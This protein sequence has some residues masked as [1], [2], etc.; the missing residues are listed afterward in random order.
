MKALKPFT[1]LLVLF[2]AALTVSSQNNAILNYLAADAKTI[3]KINPASLRQ[4]MKWEDLMKYKMFE[5]FLKGVPED[6][7]DFIKNPAHTGIDLDQGL[8]LVMAGTTTIKK[9]EPVIYGIPRDT[10]QF[11]AMVKKLA[12]G[13]KPVKTTAGKIVINKNTAF[14]WNKDIF[15]VTGTSAKG[16]A[17]NQTATAKANAE[18]TKTKQ[19][20]ERC[21]V[22]LKK[23]PASFNNEYFNAL[24]Q[25][26]GDLYLWSDNTIQPSEQKGKN[27]QVFGMINK[28]LLRNSNYT[29][30]VIKFESGKATMHVKRYMPDWFDSIYKKYPL[31]NINAELLKKL[32]PGQPILL[33]SFRFSPAMINEILTKAG[34]NDLLDSLHKKNINKEDIL[35]A[36]KGDAMLAVTKSS[37]FSEDDSVTAK[38]HG[39]QVLVAGSI[40]DKEKFKKLAELLQPK[41]DSG[42]DNVVRKIP[43]P[44]IFS[45]DSIFVLSISQAAAQNF[46]ASPAN[47][48][49]IE[50]LFQP[51]KDYP[52]AA[53]VDLKTVFALAGPLIL[54]S[55]TQEE[56]GH[57]A[58]ILGMFDQLISYGGR[59]TNTYTSGTIE[60]TLVK[61]DENSLKQ[62]LN[63]LDLLNSMKPKASTAY[64][65]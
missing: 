51:Y 19:L 15:I 57:T 32:P 50:N 8:Y 10:A 39:L 52:S 34:A 62:F 40:N 65:N 26:E 25:E 6:G 30:G 2:F 9:A 45:N 17:V 20:S 3:I 41:K 29:S 11:A 24:L 64:N 55:K 35:A 31:G 43:K 16:E 14:A 7:K 28:N 53:I 5:D 27:P 63:L 38:L 46:L 44:F 33:Y 54:K 49:K 42:S 18:L 12:P 59:Y 58:E 36:L 1:M 56:A 23:R 60:L 13:K 22:L 37:D 48:S 4:K 61:K 47:N 21:K